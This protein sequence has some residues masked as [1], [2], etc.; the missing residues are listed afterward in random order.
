MAFRFE[1]LE[2][3]HKAREFSTKI[4]EI[5]VKFPRYEMYTL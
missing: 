1:G 2:I 3:W 5:T 4:H